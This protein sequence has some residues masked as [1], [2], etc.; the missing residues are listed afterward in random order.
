MIICIFIINFKEKNL[1][2]CCIYI[3]DNIFL[4]YYIKLIS[5]SFWIYK[6]L[7]NRI[8]NLDVYLVC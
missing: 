3:V 8:F 6:W 4:F 7:L 2:V 1:I 5:G